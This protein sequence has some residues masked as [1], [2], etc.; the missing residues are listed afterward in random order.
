MFIILIQFDILTKLVTLIK[1]C[2][3]KNYCKAH[4]DKHLS[5]AFPI[6]NCLKQGYAF[7]P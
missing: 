6:Q 4:T 2:L 5:N 1:L 3:N 7:S